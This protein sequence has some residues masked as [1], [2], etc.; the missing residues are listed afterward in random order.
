MGEGERRNGEGGRCAP[1]ALSQ[2]G[3]TCNSSFAEQ[4][5]CIHG[6]INTQASFF[7]LVPKPPFFFFF[8]F[9]GSC[10]MYQQ[11]GEESWLERGYNCPLP[12]LV[13][14]PHPFWKNFSERGVGMRLYQDMRNKMGETWKRDYRFFVSRGPV[15][16]SN[17]CIAVWFTFA[18]YNLCLRPV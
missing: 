9:F 18:Y 10:S 4:N 1:T 17:S 5:N 7:S 12:R 2:V 14:C 11:A 15:C 16:N 6:I 13:S 3:Q 8:L